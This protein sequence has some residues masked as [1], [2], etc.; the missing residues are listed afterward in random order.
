MALS[1]LFDEPTSNL[2]ARWSAR[3]YRNRSAD[4]A[5]GYIVLGDVYRD[6]SDFADARNQY[7]NAIEVDPKNLT[8]HAKR[9]HANTFLGDYS[10]ANKDFAKAAKLSTTIG[11]KANLQLF[12]SFSSLYSGDVD[13][14]LAANATVIDGL[15]KSDVVDAEKTFPIMN[16]YWQRGQIA[17]RHGK[18][19]VAQAAFDERGKW[20]EKAIVQLDSPGFENNM[21]AGIAA[22]NGFVAARTGD[23]KTAKKLAEQNKA[24]RA[25]GNNPRR[26]ELYHQLMGAIEY[27]SGNFESAAQH[28]SHADVDWILVKYE[29]AMAHEKAGNSAEAMKLYQE[30]ADWNFNG[31]F[32]PLYKNDAAKKVGSASTSGM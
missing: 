27:E 1:L 6:A 31:V 7:A 13:A 20:I 5:D 3:Q 28:L 22:W 14:G 15:L 32:T 10:A 17:L 4:E 11:G 25:N 9:G 18:Y 21:R 29:T 26:Y 12:G 16:A 19:D 30:V 8:A 24:L 23:V 2:Q